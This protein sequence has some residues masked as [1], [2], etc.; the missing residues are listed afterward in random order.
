[1]GLVPG[2]VLVGSEDVIGRAGRADRSR[3]HQVAERDGDLA[4]GIEALDLVQRLGSLADRDEAPVGAAPQMLGSVRGRR[5]R[6]LGEGLQERHDRS[7]T[8][9]SGH[10][11]PDLVDDGARIPRP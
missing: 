3:R 11:M 4:V 6:G 8:S 5:Q 2:L 9:S 7:Q 1:M 10:P